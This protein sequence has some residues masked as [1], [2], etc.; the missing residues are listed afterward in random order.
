MRVSNSFLSSLQK[1]AIPDADIRIPFQLEGI[2]LYIPTRIPST[3][4]LDKQSGSYLLLTP[5]MPKWNP[6]TSI[7]KDQ[8][9]GMMDYNGNIKQKCPEQKPDDTNVFDR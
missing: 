8:E 2:I 7:Y 6:H 4:E 3:D 9:F 1:A 5:N